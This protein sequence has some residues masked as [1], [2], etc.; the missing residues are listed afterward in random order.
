MIAVGCAMMSPI[1]VHHILFFVTGQPSN[2]MTW[3]THLLLLSWAAAKGGGGSFIDDAQY[4]IRIIRQ[5]G[6]VWLV[7]G[8][9]ML[10]RAVHL[11]DLTTILDAV[12]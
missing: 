7:I 11:G 5:G 9:S 6:Q 3:S 8:A 10:L 1:F 2:A 12:S 4:L